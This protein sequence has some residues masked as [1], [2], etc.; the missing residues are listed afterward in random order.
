MFIIINIIQCKNDDDDNN[1]ILYKKGEDGHLQTCVSGDLGKA[2][3][4]ETSRRHWRLAPGLCLNLKTLDLCVR[5]VS[6]SVFSEN[7]VCC[8][9]IR[10]SYALHLKLKL[11]TPWVTFHS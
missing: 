9:G 4:F 10:A 7:D 11:R 1:N 3:P 5:F 6:L 2:K 8:Q